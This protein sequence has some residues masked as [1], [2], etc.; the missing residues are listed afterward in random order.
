MVAVRPAAFAGAPQEARSQINQ[1][2]AEQTAGKITDLLGPGAI[3]AAT[4]LVLAN[5][6]YLKAAWA[7]PFPGARHVRCPV[8]PRTD[9]RRPGTAMGS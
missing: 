8:L 2:I 9:G 4:R 1:L 3:S 5:A 7:V 6:V